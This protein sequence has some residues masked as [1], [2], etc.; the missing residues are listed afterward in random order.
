M[1]SVEVR[2]TTAQ[3][4]EQRALSRGQANAVPPLPGGKA[5]WLPLVLELVGQVGDGRVVELDAKAELSFDLG[6]VEARAVGAAPKLEPAMWREYYSFLRGLRLAE[7]TPAG[8][9]LTEAGLALRSLPTAAG[10]SV[11]LADRIRLFAE[12]LAVIA[13]EP[14][15]VDG[16]DARIRSRYDLSWRSNTNTRNRMDWQEILG[17]IESTG[18]RRWGIT[19]AGSAVLEG[20]V[21]VTPEAFAEATQDFVAI[22]VPPAGI[23]ALLDEFT[24]SSRT[25]ESRS[26]YNIWVP[27]P[28]SHPNKVENLR[29]IINAAFEKIEREELFVFISKTFNLKRSSVESMLPFMRASGILVEVGRGVYQATPAARAWVE[30]GDDLNFIRILHA[31]MR[32]VGEAIQCV[33]TSVPRSEVYSQAKLFGLNNEKCRWII[34]FLVDTGLVEEPR[35]GSLR[36]TSRGTALAAGLPLANVPAYPNAPVDETAQDEVVEERESRSLREDLGRLSREPLAGGEGSGRAFENMVRDSFLALGFEAQTVGGSG[37]TDVLVRWR[38]SDGS[39]LT[40]I[41]EAKTRSAGQVTH[42]DVSDVAIETHKDRHQARFVAIVAPG[43]SGD[44]LKKMATQKRWALL[45]AEQLGTLAEASLE[46]GLRPCEVGSIFRVP[47]GVIDLK[48]TITARRREL[49]IMSFLLAKFAEEANE[50][51]EA[52]SARDISRDGRRTE[53]APSVEEVVEAIGTVSR[54]QV[55][56]LQ[57]VDVA[58]DPK[59]S[60]YVL[61]DA[62]AGAARLRALAEAIERGAGSGSTI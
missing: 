1:E 56:V 4:A 3:L 29:V 48:N 32:F 8:I 62:S 10:L 12:V 16:V 2:A 5:V 52:I 13:E 30:S 54:L 7:S 27:S 15:T 26:T 37:D 55:E 41:V 53:L 35:Y 42:N 11:V 6:T 58:D 9:R 38:G 28:P 57:P 33:E 44:T 40:A 61:G 21:L 59:F 17:L 39:L 47:D 34:S 19:P 43:F 24:S 51:G 25:H 14:L 18:N 22:S 60:T 45:D 20:R 46:L 50:S 23:E 36:A 31:H 49:D